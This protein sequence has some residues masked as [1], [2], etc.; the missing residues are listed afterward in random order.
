MAHKILLIDDDNDVRR[1]YE[2]VFKESGFDV[3]VASDGLEGLNIAMKEKPDLIFTGIIMPKMDGFTLV[4]NLRKYV[5]TA[6]IP[7]MVSSHMGR[8]EDQLKAQSMGIKDFIIF[9]L[10]KPKDVA[11]LAHFR[12]EGHEKLY[13]VSVN[14]TTGDAPRLTREF[15]FKPYLECEHHKGEKLVLLLTP[16]PNHFE[17]FHAKFVCPQEFEEKIAEEKIL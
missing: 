5:E 16:D 6:S 11:R 4:D 12:I 10:A 17:E 13:F 15:G 8:K 9:G 14:E 3:M 1:W 7:V 2:G